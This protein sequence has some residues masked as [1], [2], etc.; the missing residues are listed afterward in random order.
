MQDAP[1]ILLVEDH[2]DSASLVSIWLERHRIE[3]VVAGS[4]AEAVR[5][6]ERQRFDLLLSDVG[7][8]DGSGLDLMRELS[9]RFGL[10]GIALSG[11]AYPRDVR[12]SREAGF[13][14]HLVKPLDLAKL[15]ESVRHVLQNAPADGGRPQRATQQLAGPA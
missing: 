7:L 5:L 3:V 12:A 11:R 10:R 15:V 1:K 9:R 14:D 4:C 13:L 2:A 6:C 8:A